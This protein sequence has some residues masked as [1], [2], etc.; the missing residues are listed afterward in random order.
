MVLLANVKCHYNEYSNRF[1]IVHKEILRIMTLC[2]TS[3][4]MAACVYVT[5]IES[6]D[7]SN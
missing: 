7:K 3:T 6:F 1:P 2:N 4:G 5:R